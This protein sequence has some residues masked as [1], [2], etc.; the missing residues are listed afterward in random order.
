[1]QTFVLTLALVLSAAPP[2]AAEL[3][4]DQIVDRH[5]AA[6]GGPDKIRDVRTIVFSGGTYRE[7]GHVGSG[8]AFMAFS[9]PHFRVVGNPEQAGVSIM[10]G[11]DGSAWEYYADPGIVVRT[12]GH[13][14][15]ASR[16][17]N[18]IDWRLGELRSHGSKVA[19][20]P[21]ETIGG[22]AAYRLIVTLRDGFVSQFFID[23]ETFLPLATRYDAPFHAFGNIV[24]TESRM[25]DWRNVNGILFAF[26]D[27]EVDLATGKELSSMSWGKIEINRELPEAWFSPPPFRRSRLQMLLNHLDVQRNDPAAVMW[28]YRDFRE[29]HPEVDTREGIEV[30]GYQMLKMG[31]HK[32][33]IA[34]LEANA[35]DYPHAPTS[36]FALG[37]AYETA[38]EKEKA[39]A[40][41]QRA[42]RLKP[43]YQ[44]AADALQRVQ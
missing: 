12:V 24:K 19:R 43:G 16:H 33:S 26:K 34:L 10:E 27:S 2:I 29:I 35:R 38:G 7:E 4:A 15:G 32:S 31:D 28:T 39:R 36:A 22:R 21:D 5:V 40:E 42:L 25:S 1:M 44:R 13:A 41:Y 3:T 23:K 18:Y 17:G 11:Y 8:D 6:R 9:R 14:A 20:G 37:R 30:I